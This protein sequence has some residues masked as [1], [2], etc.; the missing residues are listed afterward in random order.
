M[1]QLMTAYDYLYYIFNAQGSSYEAPL[2]VSNVV[3]KVSRNYRNVLYS[4][5]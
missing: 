2:Q 1:E 3:E 4:Y 5:E